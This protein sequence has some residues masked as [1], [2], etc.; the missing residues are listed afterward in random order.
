M[1]VFLYVACVLD[2]ECLASLTELQALGEELGSATLESMRWTAGLLSGAAGVW[3]LLPNIP[4]PLAEML[5]L[6]VGFIPVVG[7]LYDLVSGLTG[8]D[9][10][11]GERLPEWA[12]AVAIGA[13]F[14]PLISGKDLRIAGEALEWS[15]EAVAGYRSFT[16]DNFR[17][18]LSR[19][20]RFRPDRTIEAHYV[21]PVEF[22]DRFAALFDINVHEPQYG[23]WVDK[24]AHR[25]WSY[26]YNQKWKLFFERTK[27]L[28]LQQVGDF[29]VQLAKEYGFDVYLH[30]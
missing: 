28:S 15:D 4:R 19:F 13:A 26:Q 2:G 30:R 25:G 23:A 18:N 10:L 16:R 1:R 9:P 6:G 11:T 17:E 8:Y 14:V 22:Q 21:L 20:T 24:K 29:A 27:E 5:S 7:D 12:R 3:P